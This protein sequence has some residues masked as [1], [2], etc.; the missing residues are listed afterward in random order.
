MHPQR[1]PEFAGPFPNLR[2]FSRGE[3]RDSRA[4][5]SALPL[6][7]K[8]FRAVFRYL[9]RGYADTIHLA[10]SFRA[11]P[12]RPE[13]RLHETT[14]AEPPE[15]RWPAMARSVW[16]LLRLRRRERII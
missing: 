7:C 8:E 1:P 14:E 3:T 10:T 15:P 5:R 2:F 11:A 9:V 6:T 4:C 13:P 12:D 16:T